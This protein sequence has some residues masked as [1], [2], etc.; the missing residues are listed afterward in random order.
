MNVQRT[1]V[2]DYVS[3]ARPS[4]WIKNLFIIPGFIAAQMFEPNWTLLAFTNLAIA[5]ISTCLIASSNYVINEWLDRKSDAFHPLKSKR[6][7]VSGRITVRRMLLMY[8]VLVIVGLSF[9]ATI[10][11]EL[12]C[13]Q[14]FFMFMGWLY[15]MPPIRL[16]DKPYLD[17]ISESINNPI[18]LFVGWTC[19]MESDI[20]PLSL[21]I[22]Y[23]LG[24]GVLNECK[25]VCRAQI[26]RFKRDCLQVSKVF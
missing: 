7:S 8:F 12:L 10:S 19:I 4:H 18:R 9:S 14:L 24:G 11:K 2:A 15:N 17:V 6:P 1:S 26:S 5:V 21:I 16:K 3:I 22:G 23:W 25:K 13:V 20:P